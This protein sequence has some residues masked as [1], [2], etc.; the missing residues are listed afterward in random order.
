[1]DGK[2]QTVTVKIPPARGAE[3]VA[4]LLADLDKRPAANV[5]PWF[6]FEHKRG[7]ASALPKAFSYEPGK[8]VMCALE[9]SGTGK[10]AGSRSACSGGGDGA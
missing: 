4:A 9:W 5:R 10:A 6:D 1:M 7:V 8:G 3:I 2:A